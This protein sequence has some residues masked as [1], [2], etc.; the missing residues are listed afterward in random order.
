MENF[1]PVICSSP[2]FRGIP[3][4]EVAA[5]LS[6]LEAKTKSYPKD[7]FLMRVGD[8]TDCLYI[9]LTGSIL[10]IQEDIW[11]N[12]NIVSKADAGQTFAA[13]Y[14]CAPNARLN[15]NVIAETP[16]T[17]MLMNVKRI[18]NICPSACARHNG[19]IKNLI[20]D[21]AEKNLRFN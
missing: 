10:I 12:R 2:L 14:A 21:L 4:E 1:L 9:V 5:M 13:A 16:V 17:V 11:G 15:V 7:T 8:I 18:L 3:E 20:C 6:C 19:I